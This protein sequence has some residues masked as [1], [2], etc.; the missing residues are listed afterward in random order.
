MI[1]DILGIINCIFQIG[2]LIYAAYCFYKFWI[3]DKEK[4]RN[5]MVWNICT[6]C[7]SCS[8]GVVSMGTGNETI[9]DIKENNSD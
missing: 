4:K 2:L 3:G 6:N 8:Y 1:L 5:T 7:K 9:F